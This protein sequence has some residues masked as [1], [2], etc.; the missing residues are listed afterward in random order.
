MTARVL[1]TGG[2][3]A[4]IACIALLWP[5]GA[6]AH[7]LGNFSTNQLV[8]VRIDER[9][10]RIAYVLDEAEI[11]TFQQ[12]QRH[13]ADDDGAIAGPER[14]PLLD[15]L[16]GEAS[17]GLSLTADGKAVPLGKPRDVALSFAPGQSGLVLT[18]LE[19]EYAAR[20]PR[21]VERVELANDAFSGRV[22]WRAFQAVPGEG[23]SVTSSVS[24]SDPTNGL[25]TYP[26]DLLSSPPDERRASFAVEPG[27]G[28][29]TAPGADGEPVTT[30][31]PAGGAPLGDAGSAPGTA[32]PSTP[33]GFAGALTDADARGLMIILLLGAAFG[34]GALHA[35]SPGHGK[36]MIAGYLA[37]SRGTPRDALILGATVTVTHTAAVFAFGL[38][39]LAA[40]EY[41]LPERLYPW[42][43]L[44]SGL[45]VIAIG[46]AVMRSRFRRWRALRAG[47]RAEE[48]QHHHD[49]HHDHDHGHS[50]HHD[51][52]PE[53]PGLRGLIGLGVSGGLVP[54]P[55]A[56][57]VLIAAI[58]QHRVGLGMVLIGAF[59]LG[60]AAT[61]T[62][63][64]LAV[65]WGER[66]VRRV[67]PERR[68]FGARFAGAL[69]AV[70]AAVIVLAG[71]LISYRA[72][73]E[74]G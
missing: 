65:I 2:V 45:M 25:S 33:G 46:F 70:S 50:H 36:A 42:L 24:A 32:D 4:V 20:L 43:G 62:G 14:A 41:I 22:G 74:L 63:V 19:A 17:A 66:L 28:T 69:P 8:Q 40:S 3:L 21:G 53:R 57:V 59:S 49:H 26:E 1:G 38:I 34:W 37:G 44:A 10:A 67:R 48:H 13:D 54:C 72:I 68:L 71:V 6:G 7:P 15:E 73:P 11:P 35:L 55:S 47:G 58:S 18:R 23:T 27:D 64:G 39:T 29:V 52:H 12:I 60:L 56:L 30:Q 16:L 31:G 5:G 51:H 61:V 9:Q